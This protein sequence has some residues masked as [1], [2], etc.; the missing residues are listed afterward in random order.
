VTSD[1]SSGNYGITAFG[2]GVNFPT[3]GGHGSAGNLRA[4]AQITNRMFRLQQQQA[5]QARKAWEFQ[6]RA[7]YPDSPVT[8]PLTPVTVWDLPTKL[9]TRRTNVAQMLLYHADDPRFQKK[10]VKVERRIERYKT[11]HPEAATTL[12]ARRN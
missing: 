4:L 1:S 6:L 11:Q 9:T 2:F 12:L 7:A 8:G 5:I 10:A 3:Q